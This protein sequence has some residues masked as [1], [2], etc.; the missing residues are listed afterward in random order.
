MRIT[1]VEVEKLDL[2]LQAALTVAYGS[3]PV[4]NYALLKI[5]TDDGLIGLGEAS[6]DPEVTGE[7]QETDIAALQR[8]ASFLIG[9][10]P[11]DLE[12]IIFKCFREI[13]Q[14]PS[15]IAA[16]DMALYDLIG[17]SR[18][19]PVHQ[20]LGGKTRSSIGLYPVIPMEEPEVMAGMS[21]RF[22]QMG[23]DILKIKLGSNP[24][25]DLLRLKAIQNAVGNAVK[26]RLDINQGWKDAQTALK[27]IKLLESF[28][29]E[30]IEQ[31]V[32]ASDLQGL[33][34]VAKTVDIPIMAD[35]SCHTPEDVQKV[36]SMRA[37]D[38]INIKLM[39]CGGI[40]Q[41]GKMLTLA[42]E[43]HIPCILGSMAESSIGSAAGL[44]FVMARPGIIACELIAPLF[45]NNDPATGFT[46]ELS[47]FQAIASDK[48]G[49]GVELK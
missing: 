34:L 39:K 21:L 17:K 30:W 11:L 22:I 36:I 20:V 8:A 35:E 32:A 1:S 13:P 25:M 15:A 7:T 19:I 47:T 41:A 12:S 43:A 28:N 24:D 48:P 37:A 14:F 38:M 2:E 46:V 16:I 9:S 44:H 40:Y 26:F 5:H 49:L 18:K 42:E 33:A 4:L 6:P 45:I 27:T 10:D 23:L 29:I 3:Y 31:P